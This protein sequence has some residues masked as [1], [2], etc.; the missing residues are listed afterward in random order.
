MQIFETYL[1]N[2][3]ILQPKVF[4]DER[5]YF[6]ESFKQEELDK[7]TEYKVN[8]VQE[9]QS[10]S[11]QNVFRGFHFQDVAK[12]Q[13]KLVRVLKGTVVDIVIDIRPNSKTFGEVFQIELSDKNNLQLF[14]PRGFA[15]GFV[16][17]SED[18]IFHYKCDNY[19]SKEHENGVNPFDDALKIDWPVSK[20][21]LIINDRDK[22]WKNLNQLY[23]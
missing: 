15:H 21:L 8:F 2:L 5:G 9:N 4:Q 6:F 13:A 23:L 11:K 12:A 22:N 16:V 7:F 14:V 17:T 18:A 19:Y 20:D 3:L 1:K 10:F